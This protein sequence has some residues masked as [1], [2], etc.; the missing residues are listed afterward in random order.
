MI[1]KATI[2]DVKE[3][4]ALLSRY[5]QKGLLLGR[6]MSDLYEQLRDFVVAT[7]ETGS[8]LLGVCGLHICWE[9][10]AEIRSLAVLE[11]YMNQGIGAQLVT[12]CLKEAADL[13]LARVFVLT[14]VPD[15]FKKLG[16]TPVDKSVLPHKV[17][18]DCVKCVKF[19]YCDEEALLLTLRP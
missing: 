9:D 15:F 14:Y 18:G 7:D 16:F 8:T 11:E 1:R 13:G 4:H 10:I 17:W 3:I 19:P 5:A 2:A 12:V 6:S